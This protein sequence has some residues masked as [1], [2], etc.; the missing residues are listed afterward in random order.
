MQHD[1][2]Q[3]AALLDPEASSPHTSPH[4]PPR[5]QCSSP[6]RFPSLRGLLPGLAR[7]ANS[8]RSVPSGQ[9][10]PRRRR[11]CLA[12]LVMLRTCRTV[13]EETKTRHNTRTCKKKK[14]TR[15]R[16]KKVF[17]RTT[18]LPH[19]PS[20]QEQS[21][22]S[23]VQPQDRTT[24]IKKSNPGHMLRQAHFPSPNGQFELGRWGGSGFHALGGVG[25]GLTTSQS[26]CD[27]GIF[28]LFS[29][30]IKQAARPRCRKGFPAPSHP[31]P[32]A[33]DILKTN[34]PWKSKETGE[35]SPPRPRNA[36]KGRR[37]RLVAWVGFFLQEGE[38]QGRGPVPHRLGWVGVGGLSEG[39]VSPLLSCVPAQRRF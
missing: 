35:Q 20:D 16:K 38:R 6:P 26:E 31:R 21:G 17:A 25:D 19:S 13:T 33:G 39:C 15:A 3:V 22:P 10:R 27:C 8:C 1:P 9:Q 5:L 18:P 30:F 4:P 2:D 29:C 36:G 7:R 37:R 24:T 28:L 11:A 12:Q 32:A 23:S 34:N 14:K